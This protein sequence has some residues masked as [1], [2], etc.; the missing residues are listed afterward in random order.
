MRRRDFVICVAGSAALWPGI[1]LAQQ[2]TGKVWRVAFL[3]P[4]T[5]VSATSSVRYLMLS[6]PRCG[7]LATPRTKT[8]SSILGVQRGKLNAYLHW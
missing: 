7:S 5:P 2:S 4:E 3:H 1:A 6:A 8:F